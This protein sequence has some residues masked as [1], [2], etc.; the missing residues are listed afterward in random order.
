M[1]RDQRGQ[2]VNEVK[3][4]PLLV[5]QIPVRDKAVDD[6]P[7]DREK[8]IHIHP[9]VHRVEKGVFGADGQDGE[10][11]QEGKAHPRKRPIRFACVDLFHI[12]YA[13]FSVFLENAQ[14]SLAAYNYTA[15]SNLCR[16][17]SSAKCP[18]FWISS[19]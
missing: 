5:I 19:S 9:V 14:S 6:S 15:L 10:S 18:F 12:P 3:Q 8:T 1:F 17:T 16:A 13:P 7:S 11:H 2:C 4:R